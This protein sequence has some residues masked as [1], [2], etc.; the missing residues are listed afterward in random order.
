VWVNKEAALSYKPENIGSELKKQPPTS[1][2]RKRRSRKSRRRSSFLRSNLIFLS[3]S[4]P[5]HLPHPSTHLCITFWISPSPLWIHVN[6]FKKRTGKLDYWIGSP[7]LLSA[8]QGKPIWRKN[9]V[10]LIFWLRF[11]S[12]WLVLFYY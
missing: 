1:P 4:L 2:A 6:P 5:P 8:P 11:P 12:L 10:M 7:I 3:S 9:L